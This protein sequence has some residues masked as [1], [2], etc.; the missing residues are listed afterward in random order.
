LDLEKYVLTPNTLEEDFLTLQDV[1][2]PVL[3][4]Y[5]RDWGGLPRP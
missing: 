2:K 1:E 4:P 3:T 5:I